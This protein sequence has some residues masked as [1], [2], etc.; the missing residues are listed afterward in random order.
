MGYLMFEQFLR[1]FFE[2]LHDGIPGGLSFPEV[3]ETDAIQ[4]V[5]VSLVKPGQDFKVGRLAVGGNQLLV[6]W[7]VRTVNMGR[8]VFY[9]GQAIWI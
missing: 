3:F 6:R 9:K 1:Q 4:Q 8:Y 7:C 2:D 5:E